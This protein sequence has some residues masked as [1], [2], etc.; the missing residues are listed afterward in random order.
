MRRE[1]SLAVAVVVVVVVAAFEDASVAE[2]KDGVVGIAF[3]L[4]E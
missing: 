2:L 1:S 4:L 3:D